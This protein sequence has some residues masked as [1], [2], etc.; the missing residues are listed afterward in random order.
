MACHG[1]SAMP[2]LGA[3][4]KSKQPIPWKRIYAIAAGVYWSH[5]THT[6]AGLTCETCHGAVSQM[7]VMTRVK[8]ITS[9]TACMNCHR[10]RGAGLGCDVCH[11]SK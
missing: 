6:A 10:E 4:A 8:D 9:M 3:Y 11:E 1:K 7:D 2:A 5:R